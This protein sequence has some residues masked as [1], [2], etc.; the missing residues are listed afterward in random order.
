MY[1]ID[2]DV[3]DC[4]QAAVTVQLLKL[5]IDPM[6]IW[7]S[8]EFGIEKEND[9]YQIV[10]YR[11]KFEERMESLFSVQIKYTTSEKCGEEFLHGIVAGDI[12]R[13]DTFHLPYCILF[14]REHSGHYINIIKEEQDRYYIVDKY[15][16]FEGYVTREEFKSI[17]EAPINSK[18]FTNCTKLTLAKNSDLVYVPLT[19]VE[20]SLLQYIDGNFS[21]HMSKLKLLIKQKEIDLGDVYAALKYTSNNRYH[22]RIFVEKYFCETTVLHKKI[23]ETEVNW[24]TLAN[25]ILLLNN[26]KNSVQLIENINQRILLK[27]SINASIE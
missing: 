4:F 7:A 6:Y 12:V 16:S 1:R 23:R 17:L 18:Y 13:V 19:I 20:R 24:R 22:F 2:G 10:N 9:I 3:F 15:F 27:I 8:L 5:K 26:D 14:N 11:S 25:F 21:T